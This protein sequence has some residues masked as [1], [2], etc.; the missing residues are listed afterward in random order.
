MPDT[1]PRPAFHIAVVVTPAFDARNAAQTTD[2]GTIACAS[3]IAT[4]GGLDDSPT[5]YATQGTLVV[6]VVILV[7]SESPPATL[8]G[9]AK[10][11]L[12]VRGGEGLA[13]LT[14]GMHIHPRT[15]LEWVGEWLL[16]EL[17]N[18]AVETS[19]PSLVH[20]LT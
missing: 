11:N 12:A 5:G 4:F 19:L 18:L 2:A 9:S 13:A 1:P 8:P 6:H 16:G 17:V 7:Q 15:L 3:G 20:L 10:W 14:L